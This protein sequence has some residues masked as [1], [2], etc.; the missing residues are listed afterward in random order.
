MIVCRLAEPARDLPRLV[1]LTVEANQPLEDIADLVFVCEDTEEDRFLAMVGLH[2]GSPNMVVVGGFIVAPDVYA[3]AELR[4]AVA[5]DL[6]H[7]VHAWLAEQGVRSYVCHVSKRNTRMQRWLERQGG[8][9]YTKKNGGY[10]YLVPTETR[11]EK[12]A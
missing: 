8:R 1:A 10:W 3:D 9:R 5:M 12:A 6:K 4:R 11:E 7:H 2:L